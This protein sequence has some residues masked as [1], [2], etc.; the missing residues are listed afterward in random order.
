M[1]EY[2]HNARLRR[3]WPTTTTLSTGGTETSP[4]PGGCAFLWRAT[5]QHHDQCWQQR[6]PQAY[7]E[8]K[9]G[10]GA[11]N[12]QAAGE[13]NLVQ[14]RAPARTRKGGTASTGSR[15]RARCWERLRKNWAK[16]S[17]SG[18]ELMEVSLISVASS[19][20]KETTEELILELHTQ[21]TLFKQWLT[22]SQGLLKHSVWPSA[23]RRQRS[24]FTKIPHSRCIAHPRSP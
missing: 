22:T 11:W 16:A 13:E 7:S 24:R 1:L 9:R 20:E 12:Q 15:S 14:G 18:F 3:S 8:E 19:P 23:W 10:T 6:R 5:H 17:T 4:Q 21:R 2:L